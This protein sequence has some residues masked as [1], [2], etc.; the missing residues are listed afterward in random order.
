MGALVRFCCVGAANTALGYSVILVG[1]HLGWG[2]YRANAAG[3]AAGLSLSYLLQRYWA[4]AV[5]AAPSVAE[6]AKFGGGAA[7]AYSANLAVIALARQLG[8][9]GNPI[10]Q[11]CAMATY[12]LIF[13]LISRFLVFPEQAAQPS[14]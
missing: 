5:K 7:V 3:Y 13:F 11:I 9:I 1:L 12:S 14:L 10:A 6:V 4:F 8:Y 2:D